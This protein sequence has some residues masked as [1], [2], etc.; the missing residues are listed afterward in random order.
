M[1]EIIHDFLSSFLS[2]NIAQMAFAPV[3]LATIAILAYLA[4]LFCHSVVA[5]IVRII[6]RRTVSTWDDDLF[7]DRLMKAFS[8]LAPAILVAYLLP[9]A[10][11]EE[12]KVY[13]WLTKLTEFYIVWAFVHLANRFLQNLY[14]AF[15]KRKKYKIHTLRGVFQILK[16]LFICVGVII[17]IS[18]LFDKSPIAILTAFGASAAVL[19]LVFKDTILGL[20]AGVQ[21][22]A[23]DMLKKGD[24]IVVSKSGANGEVIDVSL[25]TVKIRNWDNSVTTVPPYTLVSESFQNFKPMQQSGGRRVMRSVFIDINSIRFCTPRQLSE[26]KDKGWLTEEDTDKAGHTV[27]IGLLRRYLERYLASH[28]DVETRMT[29]MVRQL[30]PTP[31]GIPLELYFF[32]NTT[33]W[34][35]Y[36]HI[37][38]DIFN[39]VYAVVQEFGLSIYQA[40]SGS[41]VSS[42]SPRSLTS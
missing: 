27:N 25:T 32:T 1:Y 10:F 18:I 22:T 11:N 23:N 34:V 6:T 8:Q 31:Q 38:S 12:G 19:M 29:H 14:D 36:E 33:E 41:D 42:L 7:N 20:V 3:T 17:G 39:H 16:L 5:M 26:L 4:Y 30:Q 28:P 37:Q 21:L 40:P 13:T 24:W 35:A 9:D 15:D 2:E